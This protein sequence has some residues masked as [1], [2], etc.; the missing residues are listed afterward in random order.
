MYLVHAALGAPLGIGALALLVRVRGSRRILALTGWIGA[1]GVALAAAGGL[2][3]VVH[4][5]RIPGA[6]CMLIG[7]L[8]AGFGYAL[9]TIER[10]DD[11]S[12]LHTTS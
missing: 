12:R 6:L 11:R 4:A 9:P 1:V 7:S 3:S 10:L 5:L 8:T 2:L